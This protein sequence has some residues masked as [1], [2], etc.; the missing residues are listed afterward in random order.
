MLLNS[1]HKMPKTFQKHT[2]HVS[3]K[4]YTSRRCYETSAPVQ[5]S[6]MFSIFRFYLFKQFEF[7]YTRSGVLEWSSGI[8]QGVVGLNCD[9]PAPCCVSITGI[10]PRRR[11]R[12]RTSR[13]T[14]PVTTPA[15]S[16]VIGITVLKIRVLLEPAGAVPSLGCWPVHSLWHHRKLFLSL[17]HLSQPRHVPTEWQKNPEA[18][19]P[20][21]AQDIADVKLAR[22]TNRTM[23]RR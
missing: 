21:C 19:S 2:C 11:R 5:L 6:D 4:I 3:V 22:L 16:R 9:C 17:L 10:I 13:P 15:A 12:N 14:T 20:A 18:Q 1:E 23:I 7:F 8:A